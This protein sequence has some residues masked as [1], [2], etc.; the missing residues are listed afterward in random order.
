M[1]NYLT[2]NAWIYFWISDL[3]Q[4]MCTF[5]GI[6]ICL[7][8]VGGKFWN[9]EV[10]LLN[11]LSSFKNFGDSGCF[12]FTWGI[13]KINLS[14]SK[15]KPAGSM[16]KLHQN[17]YVAGGSLPIIKIPS[18]SWTGRAFC[19]VRSAFLSNKNFRVKVSYLLNLSL[20]ILFFSMP[21]LSLLML[22]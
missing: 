18:D 13:F 16:K 7:D 22:P 19:G 8:N 20:S 14:V 6:T 12:S 3:F 5:L 1:E 15:M 21:L 11:W 2:M 10:F 4:T 9:Q 17:L